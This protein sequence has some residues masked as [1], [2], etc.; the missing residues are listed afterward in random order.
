MSNL[1]W[2][3]S[4]THYG[5][6]T[7]EFNPGFYK[8]VEGKWLFMSEYGAPNGVWYHVGPGDDAARYVE[9]PSEQTKPWSG[10]EDGL[11]PV[12]VEC[13]VDHGNGKHWDKVTI[14]A[15]HGEKAIYLDPIRGIHY[16]WGLLKDFRTIRTEEQLAAE[17]RETA[18]ADMAKVLPGAKNECY[19]FN[20]DGSVRPYAHIHDVLGLLVDAGFKR[21]VV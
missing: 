6:E 17:Q 14:L 21:E 11:P 10:P 20:D 4:A 7:K 8:Y 19:T 18:I 9:R 2:P 1:N 12:G 15:H 16:I 3:E 5:A 13:E